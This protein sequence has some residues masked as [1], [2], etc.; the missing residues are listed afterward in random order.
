MSMCF[1]SPTGA[2]ISFTDHFFLKQEKFLLKG[3]PVSQ[4]THYLLSVAISG[5]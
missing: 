4:M 1:I 3:K 2:V 5:T